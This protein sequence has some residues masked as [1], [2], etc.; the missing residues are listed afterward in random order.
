MVN[1][2]VTVWEQI[3][4][5]VIFTLLLCAIGFAAFRAFKDALIEINKHYLK[6]VEDG[7]KQYAETIKSNNEQWQ[8]YFN[9]RAE[10]SQMVNSQVV[11]KLEKLTGI[12]S[13]LVDKFD[14]HDL[15][16]RQAL[17]EMSGKRQLRPK[18]G[19]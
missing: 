8:Q 7:N 1:V 4:V 6:I 3:P 10:T 17:D 18:K 13:E 11:E 12:I 16:E 9:A 5:I 14:S 15:M 2:P 19:A